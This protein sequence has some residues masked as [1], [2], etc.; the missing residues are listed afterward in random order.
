MTFG[1]FSRKEYMAT[2]GPPIYE[3]SFGDLVE[4][5]QHIEWYV[6]AVVIVLLTL[7]LDWAQ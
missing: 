5:S 6:D 3:W 7:P 1:G 4:E 2:M